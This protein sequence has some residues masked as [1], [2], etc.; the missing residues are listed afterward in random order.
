MTV[1]LALLAAALFV[2]PAHALFDVGP[3]RPGI[4]GLRSGARIG[5]LKPD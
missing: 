4:S 2:L 5:G 1:I 3:A